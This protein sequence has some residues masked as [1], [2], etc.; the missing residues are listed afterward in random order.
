MDHDPGDPAFRL[1]FW[2][3]FAH[4]PQKETSPPTPSERQVQCSAR[5]EASLISRPHMA[6]AS[7]RTSRDVESF[8]IIEISSPV[9]PP[10]VLAAREPSRA[11]PLPAAVAGLPESAPS[12]ASRGG[13]EKA[14]F[15]PG[16]GR[17]GR[18]RG[19]GRN[20]PPRRMSPDATRDPLAA[21]AAAPVEPRKGRILR[22]LSESKKATSGFEPLYEALQASA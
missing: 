10:E 20:S 19:Q 3:D 2:R 14:S 1:V 11:R 15:R 12:G 13:R 16:V 9:A 6:Q 22:E 17:G 5:G 8:A 7:A 21:P 4:A 18:A